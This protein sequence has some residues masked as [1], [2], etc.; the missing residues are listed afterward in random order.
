[1][2][3]KLWAGGIIHS[4]G[5]LIALV[6]DRLFAKAFN[7][8]IDANAAHPAMGPVAPMAR[9]G[10]PHSTIE[11]LQIAIAQNAAEGVAQ[12][13]VRRL[14]A[15]V[16]VYLARD[17]GLEGPALTAARNRVVQV[18]QAL[19]KAQAKADKAAA[20]G[21]P[22]PPAPAR[23]SQAANRDRI[24]P[25]AVRELVEDAATG[26]YPPVPD[27]GMM[28]LLA[29]LRALAAREGWDAKALPPGTTRPSK[30]ASIIALPAAVRTAVDELGKLLYRLLPYPFT[31]EAARA[32]PMPYMAVTH[33]F[34]VVFEARASAAVRARSVCVV[35][36]GPEHARTYLSDLSDLDHAYA[37][38]RVCLRGGRG[39]PGMVQRRQRQQ[40]QQQHDGR[41]RHDVKEE[42]APWP[43]APPT[44]CQE[45]GAQRSGTSG[46]R[47]RFALART[48]SALTTAAGALRS[49]CGRPIQ[50]APGPAQVQP[51]AQINVRAACRRAVLQSAAR[52]P[53]LLTPRASGPLRLDLCARPVQVVPAAARAAPVAAPAR[54]PPAADPPAVKPAAWVATAK[55]VATS[56][57]TL[58]PL[59]HYGAA[60][61]FTGLAD[62]LKLLKRH[63]RGLPPGERDAAVTNAAYPSA[64]AVAAALGLPAAPADRTHAQKA[65]LAHALRAAKI[66]I[67]DLVL[68]RVTWANGL[69]ELRH[70]N[71]VEDHATR[72]VLA[73]V[74][75]DKRCG[76]SV[77]GFERARMHFSTHLL[78]HVLVWRGRGMS[79]QP[80]LCSVSSTRTPSKRSP[81]ARRR[82]GG[83]PPSRRSAC[84]PRP[85]LSSPPPPL[86]PTPTRPTRRR[87]PLP[88]PPSPPASQR[89]RSC[90]QP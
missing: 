21:A 32:T 9:S 86:R 68:E 5:A 73:G 57:C 16:A 3:P 79:A 17:H 12:P 43:R 76:P 11:G 71:A 41:T 63:N 34:N 2:R 59:A 44:R 78:T 87:S 10:V 80:T 90:G 47:P 38:P 29:G 72:L 39:D 46:Q 52:A 75:T 54:P 48:G 4:I 19:T 58:M 53:E 60:S 18:V 65:Q 33:E 83:R 25:D 37:A 62:L 24:I 64:P 88:G 23:F 28:D 84:R 55:A 22:A 30:A 56:T 20:A 74:R 40:Q 1:M 89:P 51:A 67:A 45:G 81:S 6:H 69:A 70:R 27:L 50:Q 31:E 61:Q 42:G 49:R 14:R 7:D 85:P 82:S 15:F 8:A 66:N 77:H 26:I 13:L 36:G 35:G